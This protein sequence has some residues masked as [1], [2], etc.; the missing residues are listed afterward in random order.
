MTTTAIANAS[1]QA[2]VL[3]V[4]V[5]EPGRG[6][7][8]F[9]RCSFIF[10]ALML[11]LANVLEGVS[12]LNEFLA[13]WRTATTTEDF[14]Y[15]MPVGV[16]CCFKVF[17]CCICSLYFSSPLLLIVAS[18]RIHSKGWRRAPYVVL[19]HVLWLLAL[20]PPYCMG[21]YQLNAVTDQDLRAV[22]LSG[23]SAYLFF[24][25]ITLVNAWRER[26]NARMILWLCLYPMSTI[27]VALG[28]LLA[29]QFLLGRTFASGFVIVAL[30]GVVGSFFYLY[31]YLRWWSAVSQ[32]LAAG[33]SSKQ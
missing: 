13:T 27:V 32:A 28:F 2:A 11:G 14:G 20:L 19:A 17:A 12:P 24:G 31:G 21:V 25:L 8:R 4:G 6:W 7:R 16:G 9:V 29:G 23:L 26:G 10:F 22:I 1:A 15:G 33:Q 30:T 5:V 3:P 18:P